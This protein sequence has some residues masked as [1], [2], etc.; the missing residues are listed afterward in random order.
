MVRSQGRPAVFLCQP[1]NFLPTGAWLGVGNLGLLK[2][3]AKRGQDRWLK[4]TGDWGQAWQEQRFTSKA[5]F[6][7]WPLSV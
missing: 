6:A 1:W 7:N 2:G 3:T 4:P 5:A